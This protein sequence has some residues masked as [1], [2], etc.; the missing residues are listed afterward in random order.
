MRA[1]HERQ[2]RRGG[3]L[4]GILEIKSLR[5][6]FLHLRRRFHRAQSTTRAT[7]KIGNRTS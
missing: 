2:T 6:R 3:T 4:R 7:R 5:G 1:L